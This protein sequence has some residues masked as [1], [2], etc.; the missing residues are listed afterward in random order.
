MPARSI[1]SI[2]KTARR[3]P[4]RRPGT[5]AGAAADPDPTGWAV[6]VSVLIPPRAGCTDGVAMLVDPGATTVP[7]APGAPTTA[8]DSPGKT[9]AGTA[10]MAERSAMGAINATVDTCTPPNSFFSVRCCTKLPG[11]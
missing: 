6:P 2:V 11:T 10:C 8:A 9:M 5:L 4:A 1:G 3:V 7:G